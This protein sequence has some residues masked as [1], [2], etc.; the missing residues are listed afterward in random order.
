M[1]LLAFILLF[2][3]VGCASE[4]IYYWGRYQTLIYDQYNTPGKSTPEVQ[5]LNLEEDIEVARSLNK[6]LPPGFYAH[7][8]YQYLQMGRTADAKASFDAERRQFPE[9]AVLMD[10]FTKKFQSKSETK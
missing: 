3:L 2:G 10:R 6:P 8:G 5:V 7:L 1:K 9:S 4:S